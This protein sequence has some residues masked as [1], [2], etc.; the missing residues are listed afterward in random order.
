MPNKY[1]KPNPGIVEAGERFVESLKTMKAD[2]PFEPNMG[3]TLISL[4]NSKFTPIENID[5]E[6]GDKKRLCERTYSTSIGEITPEY[7]NSIAGSTSQ[8]CD[9]ILK[10]DT[11]DEVKLVVE[12]IRDNWKRYYQSC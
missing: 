4:Y 8:V 12:A 9:L 10:L 1:F 3:N 11:I 2:Y 6:S 7:I 5:K